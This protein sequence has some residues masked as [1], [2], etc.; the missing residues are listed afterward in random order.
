MTPELTMLTWA[1]VLHLVCWLPYVLNRTTVRG[2]MDTVGCP[3]D[4]KPLSPWAERA[5]KAHYNSAENLVAFAA[6]E[7]FV[8]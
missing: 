5:K 3:D 6:G 4:P 2:L 1:V 7:Y 8:T